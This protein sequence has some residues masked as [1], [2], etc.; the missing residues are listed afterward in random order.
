MKLEHPDH[1]NLVFIYNLLQSC[2][3]FDISLLNHLTLNEFLELTDIHWKNSSYSL[4]NHVID[5]A[6][7]NFP[8]NTDI[9]DKK[10]QNL[11]F[12]KDFDGAYFFLT[13]YACEILEPFDTKIIEVDIFYRMNKL[14]QA[15]EFLNN[16][17]TDSK[18]QESTIL[19]YKGLFETKSSN[20]YSAEEYFKQAILLWPENQL[21]QTQLSR[22]LIK[23]NKLVAQMEFIEEVLNLNPFAYQIWYCKGKALMQ[24]GKYQEALE[25]FDF[26]HVSCETY[27]P[28]TEAKLELFLESGNFDFALQELI[29]I[30]EDFEP[31]AYHYIKTAICFKNLDKTDKA[32]QILHFALEMFPDEEEIYFELSLIEFEEQAITLAKDF[33]QQAI[34]LNDNNED[35]HTLASEIYEHAEELHL[36]KLHLRESLA[37]NDTNEENWLKLCK[38]AF[39]EEDFELC[40]EFIKE[41]KA[42]VYSNKIEILKAAIHFKREE[43]SK[44][45]EILNT[46]IEDDLASIITIFEYVPRMAADVELNALMQVYQPL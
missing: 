14:E 6:L 19:Y 11:L 37:L 45:F 15:L 1:K 25:S 21:A 4:A 41:S 2:E 32:R 16:I 13:N 43:R 31:T 35:F 24:Q 27:F 17:S 29:I 44:A 26:A 46:V 7:A 18:A 20:Y 40:L 28:A 8:N 30:I 12:E 39:E 36:A 10:I 23:E 38:Y 42:A 34:I 3:H 33:I 9:I 5:A 22:I